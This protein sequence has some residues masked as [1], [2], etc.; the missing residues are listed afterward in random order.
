MIPVLGLF[1]TFAAAASFASSLTSVF[2]FIR[3]TIS[4]HC[5]TILHNQFGFTIDTSHRWLSNAINHCIRF[6]F[7]C[8]LWFRIFSFLW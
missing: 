8:S 1:R 7:C 5:F 3:S 2:D 6:C 4:N